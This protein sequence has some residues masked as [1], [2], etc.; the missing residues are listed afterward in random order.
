MTAWM[1]L[2]AV[3]AVLAAWAGGD[4]AGMIVILSVMLRWVPE[5]WE[6]WNAYLDRRR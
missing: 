4:V 2:L 1:T 6:A 3:W 5:A